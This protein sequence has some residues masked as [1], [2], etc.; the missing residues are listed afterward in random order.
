VGS[1]VL[2]R[3]SAAASSR[4]PRSR[5]RVRACRR[6]SSSTCSNLSRQAALLDT[7]KQGGTGLGLAIRPRLIERMGGRIG[8]EAAAARPGAHVLDRVAAAPTA[9]GVL[10]DR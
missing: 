8:L 6:P 9:R 1:D 3:S 2:R 7:R 5:T 4:A 10:I